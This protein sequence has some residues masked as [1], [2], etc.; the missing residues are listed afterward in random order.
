M[1]KEER[2]LQII[3]KISGDEGTNKSI[4]IKEL[5]DTFNVS[6]STIRRDLTELEK[7]G[8]V[9]RTHGGAIL[10]EQV[11]DEYDFSRKQSK[12]IHEKSSIAK[13]AASLV[14]DGEI[15]AL[16]SSTLTYLMA[17]ELNAK[18][19]SII[20]N[21]IGVV[22]QLSDKIDYNIIVL[23]GIYLHSAKTI[24]G[25]TTVEQISKMHFDKVFLGA[26][27]IDLKLGLS[28]AGSIEASS[29]QAMVEYGNEIYFLCEST[30]FDKAS[31]YKIAEFNQV[32]AIITDNKL[33]D[34]QF[35]VYNK[36]TKI[37][38]I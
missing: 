35:E 32:N 28:T 21:S 2:L 1:F 5:A 38:R 11:G 22:N 19:L 24:E 36:Q 33:T 17:A 34:E 37:V 7:T 20:T 18:N 6:G 26:N 9:K 13:Y 8:L 10:V 25:T 12:N 16:N 14:E 30:K 29:K 31:F 4:T 15:I 23:G 3:N 27:G